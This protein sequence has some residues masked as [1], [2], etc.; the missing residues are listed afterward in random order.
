MTATEATL[1]VSTLCVLLSLANADLNT[2]SSSFDNA[3]QVMLGLNWTHG[4]RLVSPQIEEIAKLVKSAS[5]NGLTIIANDFGL[6]DSSKHNGQILPVTFYLP[7][8]DQQGIDD[9]IEVMRNGVYDTEGLLLLTSSSL[10]S[11]TRD[12]LMNL[13]LSRAFF[14]YDISS[15]PKSIV[16]LQTSRWNEVLIENVWSREGNYFHQVYDFQGAKYSLLGTSNDYPWL[17]AVPHPLDP[18][19]AVYATGVNVDSLRALGS[20][21][22]FTLDVRIQADNDWGIIPITG[23]VG[24]YFSK[25]QSACHNKTMI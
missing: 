15:N 23:K 22:N 8:V 21:Y 4:V 7:E 25:N 10:T 6:D 9:F 24:K 5:L 19:V 16:R 1:L 11:V 2:T 14:H 13:S 12:M 18:S 3:V 20:L 17:Y